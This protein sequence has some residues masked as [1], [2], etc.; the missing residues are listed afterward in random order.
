MLLLVD[1]H[2][3]HFSN[4]N[5]RIALAVTLLITL[6]RIAVIMARCYDWDSH[7]SHSNTGKPE[8][9]DTF[10]RSYTPAAALCK[11]IL[12]RLNQNAYEA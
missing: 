3:M 11:S 6:A 12:S 9:E 4:P 10:T 8:L 2:L 7:T 5:F 1:L